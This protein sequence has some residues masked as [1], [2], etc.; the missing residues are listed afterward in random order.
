MAQ[1]AEVVFNLPVHKSFLYAVDD[2]LEPRVGQRVR[3]P[4]RNRERIGVV[5]GMRSTAPPS[6]KLKRIAAIID[7]RPVYTDDLLRLGRWM[8][9]YYYCSLGEALLTM[10]PNARPRF[11]DADS[12]DKD[13]AG[14]MAGGKNVA[15]GS[16]GAL[17]SGTG[18]GAGT[19]T[20]AEAATGATE[21]DATETDAATADDD[22]ASMEQEIADALALAGS[23]GVMATG[24]LT[25]DKN[26]ADALASGT[27]GGAGTATG[28]GSA[29]PTE[30]GK[31]KGQAL[32][33]TADQQT[34]LDSILGS[35]D[36]LLYLHGVTGSGKSELLL[37][38]AQAQI[39]RD[40]GVIVL[41]PEISLALQMAG[42]ISARYSMDYAILHSRLTNAERMAQWVRIVEC[43]VR[44]VI[45]VRSAIFAPL[46][47]IA[48][49]IV[50]EEQDGAYKS[51]FTPRYHAR[52]IA[53]RRAADHGAKVLFS[54]ATPS[55]EAWHY[56]RAGRIKKLYLSHRIAGA[57]Q[58]HIEIVPM[59][60][61]R[62]IISAALEK[63]IVHTVGGGKQ[64]I[65]LHN[66]RGY[67]RTLMCANCGY[68][69]Q[70]PRCTVA[71]TYHRNPER[72]VCHYCAA[73]E[74]KKDICP[75]CQSLDITFAGFGTERVEQE[76]RRLFPHFRIARVDTDTVRKRHTLST[77]LT[78]FG[79]GQIDILIGTQI[80][81]KGLNFKD[82]ELV[83]IVLADSSLTLP[84]FRAEEQ[85]F[86]LLTQVAGRAGRFSADGKVIIQTYR[87]DNVAIQAACN[88]DLDGYYQFE[89]R[90]RQQLLF[91]PYC[92][93]IRIVTRSK[94]E[95]NAQLLA[96]RLHDRLT[97][98]R[99]APSHIYGPIPCA[100]AKIANQYRYQLMIS[101][102]TFTTTHRAVAA[103]ARDV[104]TIPATYTEVDIDPLRVL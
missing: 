75:D 70:C 77:L 71:M 33:L 21:T 11:A 74:P 101:D 26:D 79:K 65:L 50:D 9:D 68:V 41:V 78:A 99:P 17:A 64:A 61:E 91:P 72:M 47:N 58:P 56:I 16:V 49:I 57:Q 80:V 34:A 55:L 93:I 35:D 25:G 59:Q 30:S 22:G 100:I 19:V 20:G 5:V 82:V 8:S 23:S 63:A 3:A 1:F 66:R 90:Q 36:D 4:F 97:A 27:G 44:L 32:A 102:P 54:S 48:M 43:R 13:D 7:S 12:G 28:A 84:D 14:T 6:L 31:G 60:R 83:G 98:H 40:S 51:S 38:V 73:T 29:V 92:R 62:T 89:L 94:T 45:G 46:P 42:Y 37:Q 52:H 103:A 69:H 96:Q 86:M 81:A 53:M 87:A 95:T 76:L 85:T 2:R 18:G 24:A 10:I 39:R 15:A 88:Y 67:G 104:T